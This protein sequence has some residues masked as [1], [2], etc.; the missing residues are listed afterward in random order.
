MIPGIFFYRKYH[1][2]KML[3]IGTDD[4][5]VRKIEED[6]GKGILQWNAGVQFLQRGPWVSNTG[7]PAFRHQSYRA[8]NIDKDTNSLL[9]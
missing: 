5:S 2:I 6:P 4:M 1:E 9:Q 3:A 8:A 7:R